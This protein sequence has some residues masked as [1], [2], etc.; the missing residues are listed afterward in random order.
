MALKNPSQKI[1]KAVCDIVTTNIPEAEL[2]DS[3]GGAIYFSIKLKDVDL[4]K[5]FLK[6]LDD[7]QENGG[8]DEFFLSK[9]IKEE[10]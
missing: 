1:K 10:F 8:D 5:C 9:E 2:I 4:L 7:K 3:S 6:K